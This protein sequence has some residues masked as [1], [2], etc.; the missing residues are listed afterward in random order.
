[1]YDNFIL[2]FIMSFDLYILLLFC[3]FSVFQFT[4][5]S[6]NVIYIPFRTKNLRFD[7]EDEDYEYIEQN[8]NKN[9][10][11]HSFLNRWFYN[12]LYSY[13]QLGTP[14]HSM[15]IF[16]DF[17]D[18]NFYIGNCNDMKA[19]LS[20]FMTKEI[21][22]NS[23]S[24]NQKDLEDKNNNYTLG[25]EYFEF[26]DK[27]NFQSNIYINQEY[28]GLNFLY[29][30]SAKLKICGKIGLNINK[31]NNLKINTNVI[32]QLKK[33]KIISKYIWTLDYQ[34]L[35]QGVIT[36]G[37]EPHFYE[38]KK[39]FY[40]Q[41]KT[42]YI[43]L[44]NINQK[45]NQN[46]WKF[47]FDSIYVNQTDIYNF[48]NTNV[49]LLIDRGLIIGTE[50]YKNY[51][52]KNY[53]NKLISDGI[54]FK[55][56]AKL[57]SNNKDEYIIFYCDKQKFGGEISNLKKD[58][59][60]YKFN[61]LFFN[62]KGFEYDFK[63]YKDILFEVFDDRIYFQIIFEKNNI[64]TIWKL[65]EPFTSLY[66]FVFNQEQKTI[67]FYNPLLKKIPNSEFDFDF[68][69]NN[70]TYINNKNESISTMKI[71]LSFIQKFVFIL[72]CLFIIF[73]IS[74]KLCMKRKI[75]ASELIENYDYLPNN[76]KN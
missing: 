31:N 36:I 40:S 56:S 52:E 61:D 73:Y 38:S 1:M 49:E 42:I 54:C 65:G 24:F 3:L 26:Y 51:I 66:K 34:S 30:D 10:T 7:Y 2:L 9:V 12:G 76:Y 64:N 45:D 70:N 53:F 74:R 15:T 22:T 32:E 48:K 23:K 75:R 59:P 4:I 20:Y 37:T 58:K 27:S 50:E 5:N 17:E 68:S 47:K 60:Y 39:N 41:Y 43:D 35:S 18:S 44:N 46:F 14:Y 21:F 29:D 72:V 6:H 19:S 55:E 28:D 62:H 67:G 33:K 71:V 16:F 69:E 13:F 57:D 25:N 8:Y 11:P 63:L